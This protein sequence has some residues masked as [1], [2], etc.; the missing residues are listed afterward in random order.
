LGR[1]SMR[2]RS[3][4][5]CHPLGSLGHEAVSASMNIDARLAANFREIVRV[6]VLITKMVQRAICG[7]KV[8]E[9]MRHSS[10]IYARIVGTTLPGQVTA[11][12]NGNRRCRTARM[13]SSVALR[14]LGSVPPTYVCATT[15]WRL[16]VCECSNE[17]GA[18]GYTVKA[19]R[20]FTHRA[21]YEVDL[22]LCGWVLDAH[23]QVENSVRSRK[24]S[25]L[26]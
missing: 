16:Q 24:R 21:T 2:A 6:P 11:Y 23:D 25:D 18:A 5:R 15:V 12:V 14:A 3:A 26:H 1:S 17:M 8:S 19:R 22:R 13:C 9:L 4:K 20:S 10:L 7:E